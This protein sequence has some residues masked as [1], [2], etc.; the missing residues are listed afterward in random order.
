MT[1]DFE[2]LKLT[3][4]LV[5]GF[6]IVAIAADKI[7][8]LFQKINLPIIT[9]FLITGILCG[10]FVLN[11]IPKTATLELTFINEV[12]LAFIAF[13]A[14]AELY[15]REMRSKIT[16][17]KWNTLGQ[18]FFSFGIGSLIVFFIADFLPFMRDMDFNTRLAVSL[19]AGT[20]FVA[21]SPASA[22]AVITELRAKGP[23]TQT[24]M[25]VTVLIDF[26]VIMLF[27]VC[28]ALSSSLVSGEEFEYLSIII[29]I[30]EIALSLIVGYLI[31]KLL[32]QILSW[33]IVTEGKALLLI[34]SG[35]SVYVL[36]HQVADYGESVG[37]LLRLEPLIVCII[38]S[39]YITNYTKFKPEFLSILSKTGPMIYASFFTL[40]GASLDIYILFSI[41][42]IALIFFAIRLITIIAGSYAGGFIAKDPSR[43]INVGW[44]PYITQAG[45]ALGLA[46]LVSN[47]FPTWGPQF[48][49]IMIGIIVLNQI[50]GPPLFKM[51]LF[52]VG[53]DKSRGEFKFD[54]IRD[55]VIFGYESQSIALAQQLMSKQ[56]KVKMVSLM[57]EGS[58]EEPDNIDIHYIKDINIEEISKLGT[59]RSEAIVCFLSDRENLEIC[60]LA[61]HYFGTPDMIVRLNE[62]RNFDKFLGVGARVVDPSTAIVSL[63]DQFVR[64][65]QATSLLLGMEP[66]QDSRDLEV[67][68]P[69]LHGVTLRDL[70][71]PAEVIILSIKRSGQMIISHGY[72]RLRTKD[73]VTF[74]GSTASLDALTLKFDY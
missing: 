22:I 46:T 13:A 48:A 10:P 8:S 68:N 15:F 17:I 11:L 62:R 14:G 69:N 54:G 58:F 1:I 44:M 32:E 53:E 5:A 45:V 63:M 71:L 72:T 50:V 56:W 9:G 25:G 2:G 41:W 7:A 21:R 28:F 37:H 74:V 6:G 65:P 64:S 42:P 26:L 18:L 47:Q 70:R 39:L 16:S 36:N 31:G 59:G 33:K 27:A 49:T 23:F 67:L 57:E 24:V 51:A 20:I 40:T 35:Y 60:E 30:I 38:A 4:M 12:A 52:R 66:G 34:L 61:Y 19:L 43:M 55:A 3:L 73:I 29:P